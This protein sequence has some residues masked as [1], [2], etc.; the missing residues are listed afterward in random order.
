LFVQ[1]IIQMLAISLEGRRA[2]AKSAE[3]CQ[4]EIE[5]RQ[6]GENYGQQQMSPD[7]MMNPIK[8]QT[9]KRQEETK[10][11]ASGIAHENLCGRKIEQQESKACSQKAPG[12]RR[13]HRRSASRIQKCI[14]QA[15]HS[16]NARR[17]AIRA[18]EE[19]E[20]IHE[21]HDKSTSQK[22]VDKPVAESGENPRG[23]GNKQASEELRSQPDAGM[24]IPKVVHQTGCPN[25]EQGYE[26][27]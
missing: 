7:A 12:N 20:R 13:T 14:A 26:D 11:R 3:H 25:Q 1:K 16:N 22:D 6:A 23:L 4:K 19:V 9:K 27:Q 10:Y 21:Q 2:F 5:N 17:E 15:R 24:Q 8:V 18:I